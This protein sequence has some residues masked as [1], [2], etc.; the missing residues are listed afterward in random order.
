MY[1]ADYIRSVVDLGV[2]LLLCGVALGTLSLYY[3]RRSRW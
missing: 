2:Y 3:R 1:D